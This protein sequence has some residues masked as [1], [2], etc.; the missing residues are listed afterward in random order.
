MHDVTEHILRWGPCDGDMVHVEG[1]PNEM[2]LPV[3]QG[4][5]VEDLPHI[6]SKGQ[7]SEAIYLFRDGAWWYSGRIRYGRDGIAYWHAS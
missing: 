7:Y 1:E 5:C 4:C 2:R 3:V 6:I